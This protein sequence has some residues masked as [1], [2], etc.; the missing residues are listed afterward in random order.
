VWSNAVLVV[1]ASWVDHN[2]ALLEGGGIYAFLAARV[3]LREP[4]ACFDNW[5]PRGGGVTLC[6]AS[7]TT[8]GPCDF[9]GNIAAERGGALYLFNGARADIAPHAKFGW[10]TP[11][12]ATNGDGGCVYA[13]SSAFTMRGN[14]STITSITGSRATRDGG[15]IYL[16]NSVCTLADYVELAGPGATN[17]PGLYGGGIYAL[18]SHVTLSN[19]V[20]IHSCAAT[21][22]GAIA[23][24]RS[25]L[26]LMDDVTLGDTN[27]W[28]MNGA[29]AAGG[30]I[31]AYACTTRLV[32]AHVVYNAAEQGGGG[33]CIC[34]TGMCMIADSTI[35][36]N[37]NGE[38][39]YGGGIAG[40]WAFGPCV[41]DNT[42]IASNTSMRHGGGVYW[43]GGGTMNMEN[44]TRIM[45][46]HTRFGTGGGLHLAMNG[47]ANLQ[48]VE[49]AR[50]TSGQSGGGLYVQ[51]GSVTCAACV[52]AD[53]WANTVA[54]NSAAAVTS[55]GGGTA[56]MPGTS[57]HAL[58]SIWRNNLVTNHYGSGGAILALGA[59]VTIGS[60]YTNGSSGVLPP[61]RFINNH[62]GLSNSAGGAILAQD[63]AAAM[64]THALM[65]S[66]SAVNGG[67]VA[68]QDAVVTLENL[69]IA[70]N[71][72]RNLVGGVYIAFP[73]NQPAV[74]H[75]TIADNMPYGCEI[76]SGT[77]VLQNC[78]LWG[79][80]VAQIAPWSLTAVVTYC[81]IAGGYAGAGNIDSNPVF[82]AAAALNYDIAGH[83]PCRDSGMNLPTIANDCIGNG[84]PYGPAW[85][86]GAYEF[87]PEPASWCLLGL[88]TIC[89]VAAKRRKM[90]VVHVV[91]SAT[92]A[93]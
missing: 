62:A 76:G 74:R 37:F 93:N 25:T 61:T 57:L 41:L 48:S 16:S 59:A 10:T 89:N 86:M 75:C 84:R 6:G 38:N 92:R 55:G 18:D 90:T 28:L 47:T 45:D 23:A 34:G 42:L 39:G 11:N 43:H 63:G 51:T 2:T 36:L 22:G 71:R 50:N 4:V 35:Q 77:A 52:F 73:R 19:S 32:R 44:G 5:A 82:I 26:T 64:I 53:N 49:L 78:I 8:H 60:T 13:A 69:V 79:N 1:H 20:R 7:L 30:G 80:A 40:I 70:R 87:V 31:Y 85:D 65:A 15:A 56:L 72:A 24:L 66:N 27:Y 33:L 68:A 29:S 3:A 14:E 88:L 54:T 58:N 81:D 46:N 17:T 9:D 91:Q 12:A 21:A 83:S 67:A